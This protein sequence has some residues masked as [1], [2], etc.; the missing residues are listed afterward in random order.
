MY[1]TSFSIS[2]VGKILTNK[3]YLANKDEI[4]SKILKRLLDE[5]LKKKEEEEETR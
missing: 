5:A 4:D 3:L 2:I 1:I